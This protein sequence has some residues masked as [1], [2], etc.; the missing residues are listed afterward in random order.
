VRK[1]N[2]YIL[3][4]SITVFWYLA[5]SFSLAVGVACISTGIVGRSVGT[6]LSF[7]RIRIAEVFGRGSIIVIAILYIFKKDQNF[8]ES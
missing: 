7:T 3:F 5:D 8:G 4:Q 1:D 6:K 2:E